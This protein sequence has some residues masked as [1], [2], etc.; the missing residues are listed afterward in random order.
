VSR[1]GV[2]FFDHPVA[3][4]THLASL[5]A[6]GAGLMFSCFRERTE[7]PVFTEVTRLLP[8][9]PEPFAPDAPGP[10]AFADRSRVQALLE[11]AG[12]AAVE[13]EQLDFAMIVGTGEDPIEDA[14]AYFSAIGPAARAARDLAGPPRERFFDRVRELARRNRHDDI[15]ALRAAAWIVT[16]RRA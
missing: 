4:F 11:Q 9:P 10:F 3:A 1:H 8:E 7:N 12:W 6:P 13:F 5:S 15:V 14:V 2:M 16:G